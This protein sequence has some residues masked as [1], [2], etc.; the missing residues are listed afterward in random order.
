MYHEPIQKHAQTRK[1]RQ[2][3]AGR[4]TA[5]SLNQADTDFEHYHQVITSY[6]LRGAA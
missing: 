5:S 4:R 3:E 2:L 1:K 6:F